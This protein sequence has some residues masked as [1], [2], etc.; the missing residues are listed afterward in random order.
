VS[1]AVG[2][3]CSWVNH[4]EAALAACVAA[5][6][7]LAQ[8]SALPRRAASGGTTTPGDA[9]PLSVGIVTPYAGQCGEIRGLLRALDRDRGVRQDVAR[10]LAG[11]AETACLF[12]QAVEVNSVDAYQGHEKDLMIMSMVRSKQFSIGFVKDRRRMNV[13]F[14][15]SLY[16]S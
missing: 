7:V 3:H 12:D 8:K 14:I 4:A 5:H 11:T 15:R 1:A 2:A 10:A 6:A 16:H 9:T 13:R